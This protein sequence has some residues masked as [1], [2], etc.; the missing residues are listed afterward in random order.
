[1]LGEGGERSLNKWNQ[2]EIIEIRQSVSNVVFGTEGSC[3]LKIG[4][5]LTP[6]IKDKK[7]TLKVIN[8]LKYEKRENI[9]LT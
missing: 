1:M 2:E 4:K 6:T 3:L 5:R 9:P 8:H 7:V